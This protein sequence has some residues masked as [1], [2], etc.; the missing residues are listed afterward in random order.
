MAGSTGPKT[1]VGGLVLRF[2]PSNTKSYISGSSNIYGIVPPN[3]SAI[4]DSNI[5][6][7][8]GGGL[9]FNDGASRLTITHAQITPLKLNEAYTW[10]FFIIYDK[11]VRGDNDTS[12]AGG[13]IDG[14]NGYGGLYYHNGLFVYDSGVDTPSF[15]VRLVHD[16]NGSP[17]YTFIQSFH[18]HIYSGSLL[19]IAITYDG[20]TAKAY[21]NGIK[22]GSDVSVG[23]YSTASTQNTRIGIW[24]GNYNLYGDYYQISAY[25]RALSSEELIQNYNV[26]KSKFKV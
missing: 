23:T 26:M 9:S 3:V 6:Y 5:E 1:V 25:N 18:T 11:A 21:Q 12:K 15:R 7:I 10:E 14:M 20:S 8:D 17:T 16:N 22:F 4:V 24:G 19:N 2:D 13:L